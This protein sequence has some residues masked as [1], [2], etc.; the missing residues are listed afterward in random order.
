MN[1]ISLNENE[2]SIYSKGWYTQNIKSADNL[3]DFITKSAYSNAIF[4]KNKNRS[5]K[6]ITGFHQ[7]LILDIDNDDTNFT[8]EQAQELLNSKGVASL[9][10]PS[11]SHLKE[12]KGVIRDRYRV[13]CFLNKSIPADI[14]KADYRTMMS[15][16]VEDLGMEEL[17]DN[18]ALFDMARLY[19]P[20]QNLDRTL[21]KK[22]EGKTVDLDHYLE[23]LKEEN[24]NQK[25]TKKTSANTKKNKDQKTS[26]RRVKISRQNS[27]VPPLQTYKSFFDKIYTYDLFAINRDID[28]EKIIKINEGLI[29]E[30]VDDKGVKIK[31]NFKST[32]YLFHNGNILYDFKKDIWHTAFEYIRDFLGYTKTQTLSYMSQY[33]DINKYR[34][35]N[36]NWKSAIV[37][38]LSISKNHKELQVNLIKLLNYSRIYIKSN[39][40]D[41]I[42]VDGKQYHIS[43][44]EID[45]IRDKSDIIEHFQQNRRKEKID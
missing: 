24:L 40:E 44:F 9:I 2:L 4:E 39:Q 12:K 7:F 19:Y 16:I 1:K 11:R 41:Y 3:L 28:L 18:K 14:D 36:E 27:Y 32:Y 31:T 42:Y 6:T 30:Y 37:K 20:S 15:L 21:V 34:T 26:I 5:Q 43:E 13:F 17:V 10:V 8:I 33:I 22:T 23:L 35:V 25:S 29:I 45:T 38:S